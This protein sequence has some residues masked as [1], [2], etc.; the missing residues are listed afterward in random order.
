[1]AQPRPGSLIWPGLPAFRAGMALPL[2]LLAALV[3]F[4]Y[5]LPLIRLADPAAGIIDAGVLSLLFIA[6]LALLV[7]VAA[8]LCLQGL[9]W[10]GLNKYRKQYF[11][12]HFNSLQPWQKILFCMGAFFLLLYAFV[13]CLAA[14]L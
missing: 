6:L 10:P 13:C 5:G 12:Q 4:F 14:V 7:F 8:S 2:I 3:C 9:I 1:M 11:Q